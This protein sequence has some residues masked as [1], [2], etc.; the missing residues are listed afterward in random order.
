MIFLIKNVNYQNF[1]NQNFKIRFFYFFIKFIEVANEGCLELSGN[2]A[3]LEMN[4]WRIN[5]FSLHLDWYDYG[6]ETLRDNP[7]ITD[8][9]I[10]DKEECEFLV[11]S[12]ISYIKNII[13]KED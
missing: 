8:Q 6:P 3:S 9:E 7:N 1:Q 5:L 10:Y 13:K 4:G 2:G 12:Q 11:E